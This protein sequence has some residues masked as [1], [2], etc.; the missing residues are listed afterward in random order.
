MSS[1]KVV[2]AP[3]ELP[4]H[5]LE[6]SQR[7]N[8]LGCELGR[9]YPGIV[10]AALLVVLVPSDAI[11]GEWSKRPGANLA[12]GIEQDGADFV[13][14]CDQKAG[15][16]LHPDSRGLILNFF[17]D[18]RANWQKGQDMDVLTVSDDSNHDNSKGIVIES[19]WVMIKNGATWELSVIGKAKTWF[20]IS[21]S[22]YTRTFPAANMRKAVE[23]V[24]GA[25]GDHW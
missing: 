20:L 22:S 11:C 5:E 25:C 24:L 13:V 21:V 2:D 10:V 23:P 17:H 6:G 15:R 19:T 8:R 7:D 4:E 14:M 12:V 16:A 3:A 18:P 9:R 1:K